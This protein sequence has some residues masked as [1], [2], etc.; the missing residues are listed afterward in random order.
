M[1]QEANEVTAN[2]VFRCSKGKMLINP[3][4]GAE[5][6]DGRGTSHGSSCPQNGVG[7]GRT[8]S[9]WAGLGG[10]PRRGEDDGQVS[11]PKIKSCSEK[12][13]GNGPA[14]AQRGASGD[15][16]SWIRMRNNKGQSKTLQD[17]ARQK[18]IL[19]RGRFT[20]FGGTRENT[21][22]GRK[23]PVAGRKL[24]DGAVNEG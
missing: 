11:E 18:Q 8:P 10:S 15:G 1:G 23:K 3:A 2:R 5:R 7:H 22:Y 6:K 16:G 20:R 4:T 13:G 14:G 24:I 19:A 21:A 9:Y 12:K 17:N